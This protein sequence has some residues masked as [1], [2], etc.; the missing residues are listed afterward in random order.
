MKTTNNVQKTEIRKFTAGVLALALILTAVNSN[1]QSRVLPKSF[2]KES[3]IAFAASH[4]KSGKHESLNVRMTNEKLVMESN[5]GSEPF[6]FKPE[7]ESS[8]Q[9]EA[10]MLGNKY[11]TSEKPE[12]RTDAE[13]PLKI[14]GWMTDKQVW[15][16]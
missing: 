3:Q 12:F 10:W 6:S 1:G 14:E 16:K 5:E 15:N 7:T 4:Y 8:L 13:K 9:I 11:F 2:S